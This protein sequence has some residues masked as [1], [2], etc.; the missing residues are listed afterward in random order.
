MFISSENIVP[1]L[2][3]IEPCDS[4]T[5]RGRASEMIRSREHTKRGPNKKIEDV[6]SLAIIGRDCQVCNRRPC[7]LT[8]ERRGKAPGKWCI[9]EH[10]SF[11][12]TCAL[13][14]S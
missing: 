11:A 14:F 7:N 6:E 1:I 12:V 8:R 5:P 10:F 9:P 3:F 4:T 2:L 13:P